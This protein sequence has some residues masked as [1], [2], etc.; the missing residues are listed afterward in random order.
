MFNQQ[1]ERMKGI[2]NQGALTTYIPR[3]IGLS[4]EKAIQETSML[5]IAGGEAYRVLKKIAKRKL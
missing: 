3:Q 5:G 1:Q 4:L 2:I